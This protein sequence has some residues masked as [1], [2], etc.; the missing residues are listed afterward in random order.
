[1]AQPINSRL[2]GDIWH[3]SIDDLLAPVAEPARLGGPGPFVINLSASTAPISLPVQAIAGSDRAHVYQLQRVEDGRM[4]Y[5]LRLGPFEREDDADQLLSKVRDIYPG[6][7]TANAGS[8][9]L[10]AIELMH[11]KIDAQQARS[12]KRHSVNQTGVKNIEAPAQ[13]AVP[14]AAAKPPEF[15]GA[16]SAI[17][18]A[19]AAPASALAKAAS[20]IPTAAAA[21]PTKTPTPAPTLART[22]APTLARTPEPTLARAPAPTLAPRAAPISTLTRSAPIMQ[23]AKTPPAAFVTP[24]VSVASTVTVTPAAPAAVAASLL[25]PR[26]APAQV[27]PQLAAKAQ[28]E[29]PATTASRDLAAAKSV[30]AAA[31]KA[32]EAFA[33]AAKAIEA[34]Q[35]AAKPSTTTAAI[36]PV[37]AAEAAMRPVV[38]PPVIAAAIAPPAVAAPPVE[39]IAALPAKTESLP[40]PEPPVLQWPAQAVQPTTRVPPVQATAQA[41]SE[42]PAAV[43]SAE[44]IAADGLAIAEPKPTETIVAAVPVAKVAADATL[45]VAAP[46]PANTAAPNHTPVI[47]QLAVAD[48]IAET[49]P[50]SPPAATTATASVVVEPPVLQWPAQAFVPET[51]RTAPAEIAPLTLVIEP[52]ENPIEATPRDQAAAKP[53]PNEATKSTPSDATAATSLINGAA[54]AI[55]SPLRAMLPAKTRLPPLRVPTRAPAKKILGKPAGMVRNG[56]S[57]TQ[58]GSNAPAKPFAPGPVTT[59]KSPLAATPAPPAPLAAAAAAAPFAP[60]TPAEQP[61]A[62]SPKVSPLPPPKL[63][64]APLPAKTTGTRPGL[65][66]KTSVTTDVNQFL[67]EFGKPKVSIESTQTVRALT[68]VELE[69][70][71]ALRWFV[72]QLSVGAEPCDPNTVPNLDIFGVYRL[73]SVEAFDQGR[74]M[75]ALRLGFFSEQIAAKAVASYLAGFYD[76]PSVQRVSVAE[77]ERF[78]NQRI[79][80][81]KDVGSSGKHAIIEITSE[82]VV[83]QLRQRTPINKT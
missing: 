11:A 57:P 78:S 59:A 79:E 51:R 66:Q 61:R 37:A 23:A 70:E 12:K 42:V 62:A 7:V 4:R 65:P 3:L 19:P 36:A 45:S 83:R 34:S 9:D 60:R 76:E 80:P 82:L 6:A 30:F 31:A 27:I 47:P 77:R 29:E 17:R 46:A 16:V 58:P 13:K 32:I 39:P 72:V 68:S 63:T 5:R 25:P 33:A 1:M 71:S 38:S 21:T 14:R 20:T 49:A 56:Q 8:D 28:P 81:R 15:A 10:R 48:P 40:L 22:P 75:H 41:P 43:A 67:E 24:A 52:T 64:P 2:T 55:A 74:P 54:R 69:D 26:T 73:Y 53:A 35:A 18:S 50:I 44:R